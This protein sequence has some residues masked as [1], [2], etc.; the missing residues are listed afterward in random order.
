MK[1]FV[2]YVPTRV[3]VVN[4]SDINYQ[5]HSLNKYMRPCGVIVLLTELFI[6]ESNTQVYGSL[7]NY[8]ANHPNAAKRIGKGC[9]VNEI[10]L[11][12]Y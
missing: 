10:S 1:S 2:L 11:D 3:T 8:Y 5:F 4:V 7:H 6:A 9:S 12:H